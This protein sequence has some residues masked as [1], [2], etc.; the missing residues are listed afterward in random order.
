M[1]SEIP[2]TC[3]TLRRLARLATLAYD[4]T[5]KPTGLRVTQLA[6]LRT[7]RQLGPLS[8]TRLAAEAGLDRSTMGRNLDPLERMGLVRIE[9]GK[10]DQRER[11]AQ[12]TPDGDEAVAAALP[13]WDAAQS[14]IA[15]RISPS[16]IALLTRQLQA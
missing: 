5:L 15:R 6:I 16:T 2:C 11:L 8:V 3:T 1:A 9:I 10:S 7:L 14:E 4:E 12:L 13:Y